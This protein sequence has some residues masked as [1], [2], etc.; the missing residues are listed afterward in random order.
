MNINELEKKVTLKKK[1][2][3][4]WDNA[5]PEQKRI[6]ESQDRLMFAARARKNLIN[7]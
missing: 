3:S 4:I 6:W 1:W 5:T 7:R 2:T